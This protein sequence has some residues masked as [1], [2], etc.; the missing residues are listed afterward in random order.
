[1][2][3]YSTSQCLN[4][5][6]FKKNLTSPFLQSQQL[7]SQTKGKYRISMDFFFFSFLTVCLRFISH[8]VGNLCN[9]LN[10]RY[11]RYT[12][13]NQVLEI[14]LTRERV[15]FNYLFVLGLFLEIE[16][17]SPPLQGSQNRHTWLGTTLFTWQ[18]IQMC[19][20]VVLWVPF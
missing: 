3:F 17:P 12:H 6:Y 2:I 1:M 20:C 7:Q 5:A 15:R 16:Y 4:M 9:S 19:V 13:Q 8:L 18:V 11:I 14:K 10:L